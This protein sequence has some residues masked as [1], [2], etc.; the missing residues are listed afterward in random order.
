MEFHSPLHA[1]VPRIDDAL[2]HPGSTVRALSPTRE[3]KDRLHVFPCSP[4][5]EPFDPVHVDRVRCKQELQKLYEDTSES[6]YDLS[7]KD[8]VDPSYSISG[9]L[10]AI[11][12]E[13]DVQD[14]SRNHSGRGSSIP[15]L[16]FSFSFPGLR[17]KSKRTRP[18][19]HA[20][21]TSPSN[22]GK[23]GEAKCSSITNLSPSKCSRS[24][25]EASVPSMSRI[26]PSNQ[27][28]M[29]SSYT[30]FFKC[31]CLV[32]GRL[33]CSNCAREHMDNFS[34]GYKCKENCKNGFLSKRLSLK[35]GSGCWPFGN[36]FDARRLNNFN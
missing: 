9:N 27:C 23:D 12:S 19:L 35:I 13:A 3:N 22:D 18:N 7:F 1:S 25:S 36:G 31:R 15:K 28:S 10:K 33:Y 29:C 6:S 34:D 14:V 21:K 30:I 24:S 20:V 5:R 17:G 2:W 11:I 26:H 4:R 32:C 16:T 8:I